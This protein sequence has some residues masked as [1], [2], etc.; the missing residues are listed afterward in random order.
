MSLIPRRKFTV[1]DILWIDHL[2]ETATILD[3]M[4]E[5]HVWS[6]GFTLVAVYD[7]LHHLG[8]RLEKGKNPYV[9]P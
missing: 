6:V 7:H 8:W 1:S 5:A 2:I 4:L 9:I 3:R